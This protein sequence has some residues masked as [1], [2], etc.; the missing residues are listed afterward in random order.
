MRRTLKF[1]GWITECSM[2]WYY[3]SPR[4]ILWSHCSVSRARRTQHSKIRM[5]LVALQWLHF[6][7]NLMWDQRRAGREKITKA[8]QRLSSSNS[9]IQ[10]WQWSFNFVWFYF[11]LYFSFFLLSGSC[12]PQNGILR[13][14]GEKIL[15]KIQI[16]IPCLIISNTDTTDIV[17]IFFSFP[18]S[19]TSKKG[20]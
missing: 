1:C 11:T 2:S 15:W 4:R 5:Y 9:E 20:C 17:C 14:D 16:F 3:F 12:M 19:F 13:R 7:L 6:A 8:T 18:F 10:E